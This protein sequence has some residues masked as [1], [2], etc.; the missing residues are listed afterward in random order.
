M[1]QAAEFFTRYNERMVQHLPAVVFPSSYT[2]A[3]L[4]KD[5]PTLFLAIIAVA[6]SEEHALQ[7]ILQRELMQ[8]FAGKV[9]MTGEKSLELV[10]ALHVAVIWCKSPL[11]FQAI[12]SLEL[13]P[14]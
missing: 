5:K 4:R 6:S 7:R 10:Q 9:F 11:L 3:D 13:T 2:V 14:P 1:D 8:H 12:E